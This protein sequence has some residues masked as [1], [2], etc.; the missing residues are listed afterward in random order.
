MK[1]TLIIIKK[2]L[3]WIILAAL[4]IFIIDWSV[5][6]IM[7]F[8]GNYDFTVGA[9][10]LAVCFVIM[11]AGLLIKTLVYDFKICPG[12]NKKSRIKADFALIAAKNSHKFCI[13]Q[14]LSGK[15]VV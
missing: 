1:G 6:G 7:I 5:I 12:C 4:L 10:I 3:T 8:N 15:K 13:T 11:L 14:T 9:Y 2:V